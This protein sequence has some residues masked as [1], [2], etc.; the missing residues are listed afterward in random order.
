[1]EGAVCSSAPLSGA[2]PFLR[3]CRLDWW[4]ACGVSAVS[5]GFS[6]GNILIVADTAK[7]ACNINHTILNATAKPH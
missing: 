1:M 5:R 7:I 3:T 6:P 2:A 4:L